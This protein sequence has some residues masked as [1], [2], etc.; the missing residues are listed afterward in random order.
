MSKPIPVSQ[1]T[2]MIKTY[3]SYM[4]SLGVDMKKQTQ[5]V[6]FNLTELMD[7]LNKMTAIADEIRVCMGDYP[8]GSQAGRTTVVLW[9]YKNGQPARTTDKSLAT[10]TNPDLSA[11]E[12]GGDD[13]GDGGDGGDPDP[14]NGGE[15]PPTD[16]GDPGDPA[17]P[18]NEGQNHP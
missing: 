6:G 7:W 2:A 12:D 13:G 10:E 9:P 18:F 4:S 1:A 8:D 15:N 14:G 16:P 5:S 17:D 11:L 3:N